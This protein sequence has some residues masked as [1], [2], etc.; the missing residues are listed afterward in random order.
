MSGHNRFE[1]VMLSSTELMESCMHT[2]KK[3]LPCDV[4][5]FPKE[6]RRKEREKE[7]RE[8]GKVRIM[9]RREK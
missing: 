2:Q 8:C 3:D 9:R 7:K 6:R 5:H 4:W 1:A